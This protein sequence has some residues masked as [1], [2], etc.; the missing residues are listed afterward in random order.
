[1][2]TVYNLRVH[3]NNGWIGIEIP[4]SLQPFINDL[5]EWYSEDLQSRNIPVLSRTIPPT[6]GGGDFRP[7]WLTGPFGL[8]TIGTC[9][10]GPV[11]G[12]PHFYARGKQAK[13]NQLEIDLVNWMQKFM[14]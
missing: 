7:I 10:A 12:A 2:A 1:M 6:A 11:V 9:A 8:S 3:K 4:D 13:L 14:Q 5:L